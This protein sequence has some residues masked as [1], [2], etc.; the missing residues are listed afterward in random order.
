MQRIEKMLGK[1][2]WLTAATP[3]GATDEKGRPAGITYPITPGRLVEFGGGFV[4]LV[5]EGDTEETV[6]NW[7]QFRGI[8]L[9]PSDLAKGVPGL[10]IPRGFRGH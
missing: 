5:V 6:F 3:V 1:N 10:Q 8:Q 4:C 7:D 9:A 2:V